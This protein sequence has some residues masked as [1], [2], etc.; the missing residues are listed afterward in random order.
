MLQ[1][2]I[3]P[4]ST[5]WNWMQSENF[6]T[7]LDLK[8]NLAKGF[9]GSGVN[10]K[11]SKNS[12]EAAQDMVSCWVIAGQFQSKS[13]F[14]V[15]KL[16]HNFFIFFMFRDFYSIFLCCCITLLHCNCHKTDK[17]YWGL[18]EAVAIVLDVNSLKLHLSGIYNFRPFSFIITILNKFSNILNSTYQA[19]L[20]R[21]RYLG[22][23]I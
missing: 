15:H 13:C 4:W 19:C 5:M 6:K 10:S 22:P 2:P 21:R 16:R 11:F 23:R 17:I 7:F 14:G 20:G 3:N 9:L 8:K 18:R 12:F 1:P